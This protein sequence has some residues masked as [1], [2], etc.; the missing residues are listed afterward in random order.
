MT[1]KVL[2]YGLADETY[3]CLS[4]FSSFPVKLACGVTEQTFTTS[5]QAFMYMKARFFGDTLRME[6]IRRAKTP[7][8][9]KMYGKQVQPFD[10]ER[11][12][13]ARYDI[14]VE[15]LEAKTQQNPHIKMVLEQTGSSEIIEAAPRD[16]IWG[17]G[18]SREYIEKTGTYKGQNLLGKAWMEVRSQL[19][20]QP[21]RVK[22]SDD[23]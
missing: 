13:N 9:A 6:S 20:D 21:K 18:C 7:Y 19:I 17:S 16:K 23:S 11:W 4:N 1:D 15:I 12:A 14:M 22:L 3:G 5:E 2:F 10:E 8:Q